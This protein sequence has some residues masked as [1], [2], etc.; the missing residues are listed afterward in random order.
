[1][2][3]LLL[4]LLPVACSPFLIHAQES[5][6]SPERV[7]VTGTALDRSAFD[8]AQSV[9]DLSGRDLKIR[10]A[11]TLG[12]TLDGEPGISG[13][14]F[15]SGASRP[16][17]RGQADN[18]VRVLNNG[19]EVFDVSNLS[20]DHAPSVDPLLS[21]AVEVV[22]GPATVLYGSSAIGGVV[23]VL[24]GRIPSTLPPNGRIGGEFVGRLGSASFE[25]SG[26][27][28]LDLALGSHVVLHLDGARFYTDDVQ[29]PGFALSDR[30][31]SGLSPDQRARGDDRFGGDPRDYV[32]NTYVRTKDFGVGASYIWGRGYVG[33]SFGQFLSVYG[34]PDDPEVD[35]PVAPPSPVRL[36]VTK[37]QGALRGSITDPFPALAAM[38]FKVTYTDYKHLEIDGNEV[39]STFKTNGL[40]SR[41]ELVHKP[42]LDRFEG[43]LGAQVFYKHLAVL[44]DESFLQPTD[45]ISPAGFLFEEIRLLG[46][47]DGGYVRSRAPS[48]A[49][50]NGKETVAPPAPA[51][52]WLPSLRAQIGGRVEYNRVSIDPNDPTRTSLLP[53]QGTS[54]EFLPISVS[55]GLVYEFARDTALA[56]TLSYSER[57]P[58]AEEL[59]AR[60]PHD[61]TFQFLIGDPNL[62]KE[63]QLGLDV[64]LRRRAGRATGSLSGFY[65]RFYDFIDFAPTADFEDG[66][67]VFN[68][69]PKNADFYGGE[70]LVAVHLLPESIARPVAPPDDKSARARVV[71]DP[72]AEQTKNPNDLFLELKADYVHAEDRGT[73]EPL[74][75]ITPL[76]I[77][78]ALGYASERWNAR[79]EGVRVNHQWR[80][81]EFETGTPGYTLL[82]ASASYRFTRGSLTTELFLRGTNLTNEEAR[83]HPSS[84][85]DV[86]P[87][88]GRNVVGGMRLTF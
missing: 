19:A 3:T 76:R 38:N 34:V 80:H 37:R 71:K 27:T 25:R 31:R 81:S 44:G 68:Y 21:Q 55:A 88:A 86:L 6:P 2:K 30:I 32:P 26:A 13:S 50:G 39:G 78:L 84:L 46:A 65:N 33:A 60:G 1:M 5:A 63:K 56:A 58:T 10:A 83:N 72:A 28:S 51:N 82:N 73:G 64:S 17:I 12:E 57:A 59:Y 70:A 42:L 22:R 54:R 75:R 77:G 4:L 49:S 41:L 61:A 29:V 79:I 15:T 7:V 85:K 53:G 8:T 45:T 36:D 18:R 47:E 9:S 16:I 67:R 40:D 24:D 43:S 20:P 14:G 23:N 87:L 52:S 11:P 69:A 62:G 66:L 35:D 48:N 74:P